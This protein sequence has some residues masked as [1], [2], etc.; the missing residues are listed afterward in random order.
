ML[1]AARAL[2]ILLALSLG[3]IV[4]LACQNN[5]RIVS[6]TPACPT[7]RI[8]LDRVVTL[9]SSGDPALTRLTRVAVDS[10]GRFFAAPTYNRG[11]IAMYDAG[12]RFVRRFGRAGRGPGEFGG[13]IHMLRAGPGDSIHVFEGP[14]HTV[15]APALSSFG[16]VRMLPVQPNEVVFL[17][18]GRMVAH[19]MVMGRGGVGQPLHVID[20]AGRIAQSFAGT[21]KWDPAKLYLGMRNIA[22]A[23]GNRI[24]SARAGSY[25]VELWGADGSNPLTVVR[26]ASWFRPWEHEV[27]RSAEG[28]ERPRVVDLA[29]DWQGRLWVSIL[30]RDPKHRPASGTR[31]VPITEVDADT[32]FDTILEVLDPRSG[33]LLAQRR[34]E[35]SISEFVGDG[36]MVVT[37]RED[38]DGNIVVDVWRVR[39]STSTTRGE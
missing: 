16:S 23:S 22:P 9:G 8:A 25:R 30:V 24:W 36:S 33:R 37:R 13:F 15:L 32:E 19:Q 35:Q 21:E 17:D 4:P 1:L 5:T 27:R 39:L 34:F 31:E 2:R 14:R 26:N 28:L 3:M 18:D 10:R 12:G 11:E 6:S 20:P 29:E 7:C 38:A